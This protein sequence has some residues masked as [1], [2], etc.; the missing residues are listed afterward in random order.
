MEVKVAQGSTLPLH[1]IKQQGL[2]GQ[3]LGLR[4]AL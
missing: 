4:R 1:T 2:R 3:G